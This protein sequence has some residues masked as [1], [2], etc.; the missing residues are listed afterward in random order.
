[1]SIWVADDGSWGDG[2]VL[3]FDTTNW[4]DD[5]FEEVEVCHDSIRLAVAKSI[6]HKRN[7]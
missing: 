7:S 3:K 4:T 1:M 5:D 6:D 2:E